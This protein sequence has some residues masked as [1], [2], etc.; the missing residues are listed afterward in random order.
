E[1]TVTRIRPDS[2][3]LTKP[4]GME[5]KFQPLD[6]RSRELVARMLRA[7]DEAAQFRDE[8][9]DAQTRIRDGSTSTGTDTGPTPIRESDEQLPT[10]QPLERTGA[11]KA[12]RDSSDAL[13]LPR[14][15]QDESGAVTLAQ[16]PPSDANGESVHP[17][18]H[19]STTP[20][21]VDG[22]RPSGNFA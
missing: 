14:P 8:T 19:A 11:Q 22:E 7:R 21:N 2:G 16:A 10:L 12:I 4:P 13:P 9:T 18:T 15:R 5:L 20:I 17:G 3:D 6:E 1:G